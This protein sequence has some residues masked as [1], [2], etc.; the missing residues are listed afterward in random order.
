MIYASKSTLNLKNIKILRPKVTKILRIGLR[1][2]VIFYSV[3]LI[4]GFAAD[5]VFHNTYFLLHFLH[6]IGLSIIWRNNKEIQAREHLAFRELH[7]V[8][9]NLCYF[10][11]I[12]FVF[13]SSDGLFKT[14]KSG[15]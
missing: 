15:T 7:L 1:S 3:N 11:N 6:K 8:P 5:L 14:G 12:N 4:L 9:A 13:V 10:Q 2:L